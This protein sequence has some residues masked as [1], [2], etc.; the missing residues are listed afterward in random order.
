MADRIRWVMHK[1]KTVLRID[2]SGLRG[3][4]L[5]DTVRQATAF[6][7]GTPLNSV[8]CLAD[9]RNAVADEESMEVL[10]GT[11]KQTKAHDKKVA[12]LG[13]TGVKSVLLMAVNLFTG[14]QMKPFADEQ[15]ALDWLV[16]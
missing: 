2:Y 11:V 15:E 8:L 10:K 3:K 5:R 1:G 4:E 14:H 16:S 12:V 6:Y 9:V 13:I 7:A